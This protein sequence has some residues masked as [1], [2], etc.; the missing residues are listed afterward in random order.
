M[1]TSNRNENGEKNM[2]IGLVV[3][4]LIALVVVAP[5]LG[6]TPLTTAFTYQGQWKAGDG[7]GL[8]AGV[9][10]GLRSNIV[11]SYDPNSFGLRM[12]LTTG[13]FTGISSQEICGDVNPEN[14]SLVLTL[15]AGTS[16]VSE[17][18]GR[19]VFDQATRTVTWNLGTLDSLTHC[20]GTEIST[21]IDV[22]FLDLRRGD[23]A[24]CRNH[25]HHHAER[26]PLR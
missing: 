11:V 17:T 22:G 8:F 18:D 23:L 20:F 6:E 14:V 7:I 25:W 1:D 24:S 13:Y 19:S 5:A 15:P 16:L 21:T 12:T 26:R 4:L 2:R 3:G 9:I 10:L